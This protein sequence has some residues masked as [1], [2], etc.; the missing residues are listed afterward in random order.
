[1]LDTS[2]RRLSSIKSVQGNWLEFPDPGPQDTGPPIAE[3]LSSKSSRSNLRCGILAHGFLRL[4][5]EDCDHEH[6]VAFSCKRRG[7]CPSCGVAEWR[8]PQPT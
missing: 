8:K 6:L 2:L 1:M 4:K 7:F 5:C 3:L